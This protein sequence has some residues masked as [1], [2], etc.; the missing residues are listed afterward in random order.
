MVKGIRREEAFSGPFVPGLPDILL[1]FKD[2]GFETKDA[3]LDGHYLTLADRQPRG[4]HHREG[5]FIGAGP[6][7]RP[8][9]YSGLQL[10]DLAPNVLALAG[11][12]AP[13]GLDGRARPDIFEPAGV[14]IG[15]Q[16]SESNR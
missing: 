1:D 8:G 5:I 4:I 3:V 14:D 15:N 10:Q 2:S 16:V 9:T 12:V 6:R 13:E 11:L 7:V